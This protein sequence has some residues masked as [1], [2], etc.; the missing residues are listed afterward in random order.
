MENR[1]VLKELKLSDG[2]KAVVYEGTG[3]DFLTAVE[4]A[5]ETGGG[6]K[7]A[8][9]TLMEQL[10][11][12]DGKRVTAEELKKLPLSDFARLYTVFQQTG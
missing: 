3:E 10:I 8:I 1:Q 7:E 11:E 4:I 12:I 2:R 5:Q 9:L 6:F